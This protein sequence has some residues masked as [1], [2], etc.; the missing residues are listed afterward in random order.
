[1]SRDC[2]V[3]GLSCPLRKPDR[4]MDAEDALAVTL[5]R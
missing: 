3:S 2:P 4:A 1:M 5:L